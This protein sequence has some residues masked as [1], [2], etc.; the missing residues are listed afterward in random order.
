MNVFHGINL[1]LIWDTWKYKSH[2]LYNF[3]KE[4]VPVDYIHL[5]C[6]SHNGKLERFSFV[7]FKDAKCNKNL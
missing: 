6:Y 7:G 3:F 5:Q 2:S 1:L 4:F